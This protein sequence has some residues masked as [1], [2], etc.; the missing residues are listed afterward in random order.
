MKELHPSV[1]AV[2]SH[3]DQEVEKMASGSR[4]HQQAKGKSASSG[5]GERTISSSANRQDSMT[6]EPE[7]QMEE[8]M[9]LGQ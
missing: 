8:M 9:R 7:R 2:G 3:L 5:S 6:K 1:S 4:N